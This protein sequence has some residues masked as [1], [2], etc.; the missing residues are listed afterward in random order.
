MA[1]NIADFRKEIDRIDDAILAQLLRRAQIAKKIGSIK[2]KSGSDIYSSSRESL[3]LQQILSQVKEPLAI[4]DVESIFQEILNACRN[5][6]RQLRL[7]YLGPEA[8]FTHQ[9]ALKHFG[10]SANM[11][12]QK[13]IREVFTE[14]EKGRADYGVV[15]IENSTEG[16]VNHTLDMFLESDLKICAE[17]EEKISHYLLSA[18]GQ[19]GKIKKVISHP[20]ALAQ[21]RNWISSHLPKAEL[22]EVSSTAEAASQAA[23]DET[24]AAIASKLAAQI[25]QLKVAAASIEDFQE[26][27]TRFLIIGNPISAPCGKD[28]TSILFS[29]KDRVGALNDILLTFKKAKINLTKIES[30][31]SKKKVWE[32]VFFVDFLGHAEDKPVQGAL[33]ELQKSCQ[34]LKILGSYPRSEA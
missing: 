7:A 22:C 30:R 17:R 14:V 15:P 18:S 1:E 12:A 33:T 2:A 13:S 19:I 21:C 20:Q 24:A 5:I 29:V 9:V 8:T 23:L 3:I 16:V 32:Y 31:P 26:N 4:E 6:Q 10:K 25:Y 11:S 28:K 34:T 27:Y